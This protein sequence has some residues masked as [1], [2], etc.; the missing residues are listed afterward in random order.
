MR[1]Q[2]FVNGALLAL[3]LAT[4]GVVWVTRE[5]PTT[6]QLAERKGKLLPTFRKEAVSRLTL[7]RDGRDLELAPSSAPGEAGEFRIVR[8]WPERADIATVNQLLGALDLASALRAADDVTPEAAGLDGKA[9]RIRVEMAESA[10][11]LTLGGAA[12]SPAGARYVEVASAGSIKRYVVSEG[13]ASELTLPLA[14][15]R[16]ARLFEYGKSELA[17][18]VLSQ[19][20]AKRSSSGA[21]VPYVE[22]IELER[23]DHGVFFL[24]V[25]DGRELANPELTSR[26]FSALSRLSVETVLE[27]ADAQQQLLGSDKHVELQLLDKSLPAVTLT[28][29]GVADSKWL[30]LREQPG[31]PARAGLVP[32]DVGSALLATSD[33][34]RLHGPVAARGDEIE[35]LRITRG[36]KKLDLARK[37]KAFTL[38]GPRPV[39]VALDAGNERLASIASAEGERIAKPNLAALGLNPPAGELLIQVTGADEATHREERVLLGAPRTDGSVCVARKLDDV[40]LCFPADTARAFEP[41]A[42]LLRPLELASFAPSDL[43]TLSV[44][45]DGWHEI[46]ERH[47]DGSYELSE[48]K[49]FAHDGSLVAD[50]V[51]TLSTLQAVRW[52][53][54][55][56]EPRFGLATPRLRVSFTRRP[57]A[58]PHELLVGAKLG[59]GY[60][61]RLSPDPG[62][63]LLSGA[64]YDDL[65]LLL[66]DRALCPTFEPGKLNVSVVTKN[67]DGVI[68]PG[69]LVFPRPDAPV[70]ETLGALR[71]EFAVHVGPA[72][73]SEGF[74]HPRLTLSYRAS[75]RK[76]QVTV[77]ACDTLR[78]QRVCYARRDDIDAT[79][80]L[81]A[82]T[83]SGLEAATSHDTP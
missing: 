9:P 52:L 63:F 50:A 45:G 55:A 31:K 81:A 68:V 72:K 73:S 24:R 28:L 58:E 1:R 11:L 14:K 76:V 69:H 67:G 71:A 16:E 61:A 2:L 27:T 21:M 3:A 5:T 20:L 10:A 57:A 7:T 42:T 32:G 33:E 77:G 13:V 40:V 64:A 39:D 4:L 25:N 49:G 6:S 12:P 36:E 82:R 30:V 59:P 56:D 78:E 70:L 18:V 60:Y 44:D 17:K 48:P 26:I 46:L 8:P 23:G 53:A 74:A 80:A 79:F 37:D 22:R 43:L 38:R 54:T 19:Q 66:I 34:A 75:D 83:V 35:E 51:Q 47:E 62:I 29:A 41:D 65:S 15:F